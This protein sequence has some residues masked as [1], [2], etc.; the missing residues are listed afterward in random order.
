MYKLTEYYYTQERGN[1]TFAT[2]NRAQHEMLNWAANALLL[3]SAVIKTQTK[4]KIVVVLP[5]YANERYTFVIT[6]E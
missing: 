4:T 2:L 1:M 5:K 6:E 3:E